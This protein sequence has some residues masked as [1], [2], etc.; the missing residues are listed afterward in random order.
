MKIEPQHV[1]ALALMGT[2]GLWRLKGRMQ[3]W[4]SLIRAWPLYSWGLPEGKTAIGQGAMWGNGT[5]L[6]RMTMNSWT[7]AFE[8]EGK[9]RWL[10][11]GLIGWLLRSSQTIFP[12]ASHHES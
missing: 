7:Y 3:V 12:K 1:F 9:R 4:I 5:Y 2:Q 8:F 6:S 11:K 10:T